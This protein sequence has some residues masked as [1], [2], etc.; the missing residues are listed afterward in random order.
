VYLGIG[1]LV[2]MMLGCVLLQGLAL[3]FLHRTLWV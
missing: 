1:V 2:A 3:A